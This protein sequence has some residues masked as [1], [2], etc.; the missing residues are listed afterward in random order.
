MTVKLSKAQRCSVRD[1]HTRFP[2]TGFGGARLITV[3]WISFVY[4]DESY[5]IT[6]ESNTSVLPLLDD[7]LN[8]LVDWNT[9][10]GSLEGGVL[11]FGLFCSGHMGWAANA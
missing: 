8:H 6:P 11:I 3:P 5:Q 7:I 10:I 1:S 2:V 9:V 4:P